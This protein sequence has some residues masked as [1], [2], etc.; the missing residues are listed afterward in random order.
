[1]DNK[2]PDHS[3]QLKRINRIIG[4]LNGVAR[5]IESKTY[6]PEILI[7]TKAITSAIK[8][9]EVNLLDKHINH[10]VKN[11]FISGKGSDE[12]TKELLNIFKTRL[13]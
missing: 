11:S 8:S 13:K 5:M 12:K 7:Q 6:C 3:D 4:Q 1:M 10:C 9:L 2:N